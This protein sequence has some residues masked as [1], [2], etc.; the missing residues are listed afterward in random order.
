MATEDSPLLHG[1][2]DVTVF[3]A[4]HLHHAIN[5]HILQVA[6]RI[7][8]TLHLHH[9]AHTKLYAALDIGG[10]RVARTRE[11][12]FHPKNPVWN[13][14]FRVYCAHSAQSL[15]F[16][17]K[18]Q[19]PVGASVLGLASIPA[20]ALLSPSSSEPIDGFSR[21]TPKTAASSTRP[22]STSASDSSMSPPTPAGT[23]EFASHSSP[24]S[25]IP[26]SRSA[27]TVT[28]PCTRT[29]I[30]RTVSAPR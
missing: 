22:K 30:F 15:T 28:S 1:I 3:E 11:V 12:E 6:E 29:A 9:L 7:E 14:S 16:S 24:A 13:E 27:R 18:N 20:L 21:C 19:L 4:D 10:A 17:V 25:Q 26:T 8:E 23:P 2:L 5:T